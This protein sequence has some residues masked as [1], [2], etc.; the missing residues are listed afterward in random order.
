[1]NLFKDFANAVR[2]E[3]SAQGYDVAHVKDDDHATVVLYSKIHRYTIEP[4]PRCVVKAEG[5]VCPPQ[6]VLGMQLLEQAIRAGHS[7]EPHRS[8]A[9][10]SATWRDGLLDYWGIHHFHL[11]ITPMEDGFI[12]RTDELL[13][14]LVDDT[15][16]YFIKVASHS[17]APWAKKELVEIIHINWPDAISPYRLVGVT[18]VNPEIN[19]EDRKALRA[20]NI[21]SFLDMEDGTVYCE[22]EFGYT[23]GGLHIKDL[24]W[25]DRMYDVARMIESEIIRDWPRIADDARRQGFHLSAETTLSLLKTVPGVYW[26]L[27]DVESGYWFR[28]YVET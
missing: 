22:P 20:A 8:K 28:R 25:A 23:T 18:G 26:D 10:S 27:K 12:E 16:A 21:S 6:Y 19:N 24:R 14:C 15:C 5:F 2:Q 3:M 7:L 9:I 13:V 11:G 1:M 4:R 17:A